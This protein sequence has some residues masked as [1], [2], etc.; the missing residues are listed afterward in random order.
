MKVKLKKLEFSINSSYKLKK[1]VLN[2]IKVGRANGIKLN[3]CSLDI[4]N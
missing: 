2:K 1:F 3:I 4:W